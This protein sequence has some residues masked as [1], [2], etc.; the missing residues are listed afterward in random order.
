MLTLCPPSAALPFSSTSLI[1][2][3]FQSFS[4]NVLGGEAGSMIEATDEVLGHHTAYQP[5]HESVSFAKHGA[6]AG[7][8]RGPAGWT[9]TTTL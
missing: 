6:W 1:E 3:L 4:V 2:K 5:T 8:R 9:Y 7:G